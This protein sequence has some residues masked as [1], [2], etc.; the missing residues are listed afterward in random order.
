M[1]TDPDTLFSFTRSRFGWACLVVLLVVGCAAVL[2]AQQPTP[3]QTPAQPQAHH[4][5]DLSSPE[6]EED[7]DELREELGDLEFTYFAPR[8]TFKYDHK[9]Q[10][11]DQMTDRFR[12]KALWSFGPRKRWA[13]S[14]EVPFLWVNSPTTTQKGMG[15][16]ELKFGG[17][18]SKNDRFTQGA[19]VQLNPATGNST[20]YSGYATVMKA[21]YGNSLVLSP[22][23]IMDFS[24]NYAAPVWTKPGE[25]WQKAVEPELNIAHLFPWF[26][27]YLHSDNYYNWPADQWGNTAKA[28]VSKRFDKSHPW[29]VDVY[30]EVPLNHYAS[31][32]FKHDIGIDVNIYIK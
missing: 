14:A 10:T 31:Q 2:A 1:I 15:D 5:T 3:N 32:N 21:L 26:A 13:A 9:L 22:T 12:V 8:V 30:W 29:T 17:I 28:G 20:A 19:G 6:A 7:L 18:I 4:K 27:A 11:E 24:M 25:V 23:W 16:F